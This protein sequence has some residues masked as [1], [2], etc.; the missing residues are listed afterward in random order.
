MGSRAWNALPVDGR[1]MYT[2]TSRKSI[3]P[4]DATRPNS[5]IL[6]ANHYCNIY[7]CVCVC[8]WTQGK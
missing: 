8:Y 7:V 6:Y 1:Y 2:N 3:D 4:I 5:Q